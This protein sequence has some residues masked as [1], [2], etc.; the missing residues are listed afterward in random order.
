MT[1][2]NHTN[3]PSARWGTAQRTAAEAYGE[4]VDVPFPNIPPSWSEE[5]VAV[6]AAQNVDVLIA[7][8]P[9]AVLVQGEPTY[10]CALVER[11]QAAGIPALAACS[12]RIAREEVAPDGT[13]RKVSVFQFVRF[14]AYP[15]Y[16]KTTK[17]PITMGGDT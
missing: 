7:H 16:E 15:C 10:A 6:L 1:F 2:I 8:H 13:A 17:K 3:H 11:L 4:I 5:E 12:E 9:A 14:R